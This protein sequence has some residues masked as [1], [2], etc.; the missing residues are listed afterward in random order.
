MAIGAEGAG[1]A[2]RRSQAAVPA[3]T[4]ATVTQALWQPGRMRT[5]TLPYVADDGLAPCR[6]LPPQ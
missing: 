4:A 5:S 6:M 3:S 2:R 1:Y